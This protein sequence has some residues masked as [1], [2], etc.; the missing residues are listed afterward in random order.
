MKHIEATESVSLLKIK[1]KTLILKLVAAF[2]HLI[3]L[4]LLITF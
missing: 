1:A 3:I 4:K 2:L